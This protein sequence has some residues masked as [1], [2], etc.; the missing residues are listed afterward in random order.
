[1]R[2]LLPAVLTALFTPFAPAAEKKLT[3]PD[4]PESFSSFGACTADGFVYVYGGHAGKTHTYNTETALGKFRRLNLADPK[5]WEELPGGMKIQGLALVAHKGKVIRVGGMEPRNKPGDPSDNV[6][7]A[8]VQ[9]FDPKA[10]K[11]TDLPA[12]PA[13]RSSHDAV[14]VGDTLVVTGGWNMKGNDG[15]DWLSTTLMLDLADPKADW[16]SIEQ[17]FVR[18]ALTAAALDGKVYVF[19]GLLKDGG[20]EASVNI[21]DVKTGKWTTGPDYPGE[22]MN[23]FSAAAV[24]VNG[25]LYLNPADGNVYKLTGDKWTEA[26]KVTTPR[27]VHRAVPVGESQLL[28]LAGAAKG[29][30]RPDGEVIAV[31]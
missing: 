14:M 21:L 19:G 31:K 13:P 22:G 20:M 9:S 30:S 3:I 5:K 29:G 15:T 24:V 4:L 1:M 6:S 26:A 25:H 10:N 16:K 2:F 23:G 17:P 27:W 12:M 18:R 8:T 7:T 28:V 11:W